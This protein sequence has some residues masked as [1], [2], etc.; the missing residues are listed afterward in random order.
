M[1]HG[2]LHAEGVDARRAVMVLES[3]AGMAEV[4][5][6]ARK[7]YASG[8]GA[9]S[10]PQLQASLKN[11]LYEQWSR[12]EACEVRGVGCEAG[13]WGSWVAA[14]QDG[15]VAA[16]GS[17][18]WRGQGP[19]WP[20]FSHDGHSGPPL[21]KMFSHRSVASSPQDEASSSLTNSRAISLVDFYVPF[22]P[23]HRSHIREVTGTFLARTYAPVLRSKSGYELQWD[24]DVVDF[25]VRRA[26]G[27]DAATEGGRGE[28]GCGVRWVM[29]GHR[30]CKGVCI[31]SV[32]QADHI[33]YTSADE[34]DSGPSLALEGAVGVRNVVNRMAGQALEK[35]IGWGDGARGT[36]EHRVVRLAVR[37]GRLVAVVKSA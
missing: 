29:R 26:M 15:G 21:M 3:N 19:S 11:T 4:V 16:C 2:V 36:A 14:R 10:T 13:R 23:L 24:D 37:E 25:L 35:E 27:R 9:V 20:C 33:E 18:G 8:G 1:D 34:S 28:D 5:D 30:A 6:E 31:A 17:A 12:D 22:F 7:A 32:T